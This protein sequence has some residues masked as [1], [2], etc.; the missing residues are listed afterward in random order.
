MRDL[1]QQ[2]QRPDARPV[3]VTGAGISLASGIPTF[4]GQDPDA[5]W[6]ET[7]LE[8]GTWRFFLRQPV[9]QWS[10]YLRR[11]DGCRSASPNAGHTALADL[12]QM[13]P[14]LQII[15]QNVDG[16]HT[17]AGSTSVMEVHGAARY[18]RCT[19]RHC[20]NGEPRGLV[21]WDESLFS[22][23]RA[24]PCRETLPR[25][26]KCRKFLRPHVLWFDEN[27]QSHESYRFSEALSALD[28]MTCCI[29]IGTSFAVGITEQAVFSATIAPLPTFVIDPG[30]LPEFLEEYAIHFREA[31]E[32]FLPRLIEGMK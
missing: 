16:L 15:T 18:L 25:C 20:V 5:V 32:T 2:L 26:P 28:Q 19:N 11:F 6:S 7:V 9:K 27:Y 13:I 21:E 14:Q 10:W 23:F 29:F 22:A 8:M 31:S 4:R 12:E 17:A 24:N 30:P 3:V 1:I